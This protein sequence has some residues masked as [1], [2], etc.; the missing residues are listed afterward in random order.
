VHSIDP[1][2][3]LKSGD[4]RKRL[5][6]HARDP[7]ALMRAVLEQSSRTESP[8]EKEVLQRL[9]S[10]GYK[11]KTQWPVGAYRIDMIVEGKSKRLAV[12]CDGEK[13][14]TSEELQKDLQ[15]QAL[16]ERLG[17]IFSRIR[18]SEFYR[19]PDRA[20]TPVFTKLRQLDI[21]PLG[22]EQITNSS[23]SSFEDVERIKRSA[24]LIRQSWIVEV[25]TDG[26][27]VLEQAAE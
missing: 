11:V 4:I 19:D 6:D 17:W 24:Q 26:D 27:T 8:F 2:Q 13:W 25:P 3:H 15:R 21:E 20:M 9:I 10:A 18:G 23:L 22:S 5:I 7:Q 16:L 12:E 1:A 14:H